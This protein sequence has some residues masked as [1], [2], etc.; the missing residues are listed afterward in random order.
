[1]IY[2]SDDRPR[3]LA[4]WLIEHGGTVR[5]AAK[6]FG[7]S[8]STVHK[9]ITK[10]LEKL[11]PALFAEVTALLERNKAERHLRGGIATRLKYMRDK[12][13]KMSDETIQ[14]AQSKSSI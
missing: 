12:C 7:I 1:M 3:L 10:R 9:D 5:S 2:D 11:S 13:T 4:L 8:K 6:A 14:N